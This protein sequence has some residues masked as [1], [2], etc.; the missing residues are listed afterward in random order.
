MWRRQ[1][2]ILLRTMRRGLP[3]LS[4]TSP[5]GRSWCRPARPSWSWPRQALLVEHG[6]R[7]DRRAGSAAPFQ[8]Q[9]DEAELAFAD[10]RL[11]IA[12]ALDMGDVELQ[13]RLVDERV[14][15]AFRSGAH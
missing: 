2:S 5:A 13:A 7:P 9:P 12:Q 11:E 10:Q 4:S 15:D 8:R 6:H 14:H 3:A 1:L